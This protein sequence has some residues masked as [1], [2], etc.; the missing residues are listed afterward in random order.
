MLEAKIEALTAA[1]ERLIGVMTA[2]QPAQEP[3][4][5]K[6]EPEPANEPAEEVK[7]PAD[8]KLTYDYV[9][10]YILAVSSKS[11]EKAKKILARFDVSNLKEV[12]ED[13]WP[14]VV[15]ACK[16]EGAVVE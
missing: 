12:P 14:A 7:A 3:Q 4:A 2:A 16:D 8:E 6:H 15:K 13:R 11:M 5:T 1:V 9:S 10:K